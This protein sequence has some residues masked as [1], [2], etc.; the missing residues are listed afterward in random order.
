MLRDNW[1]KELYESA[2][3]DP[4]LG[5]RLLWPIDR[6]AEL[7]CGAHATWFVARIDNSAWIGRRAGPAAGV[8]RQARPAAA[9]AAAALRGAR[10][11]RGPAGGA[12]AAHAEATRRGASRAASC[13]TRPSAWS[14]RWPTTPCSR[15]AVEALGWAAWVGSGA[16]AAVGA[17]V[18]Y[19]GN[20]HYTFDHGGS[21]AASWLKFQL[22]AIGGAVQGMAIVALG[23][24]RGWHYLAAQVAATLAGL[25]VT[26]AVNRWWTFR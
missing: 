4:A 21:L 24:H 15:F 26:Y 3:F 25:V 20:R 13:A 19:F 23:V 11:T 6:L 7:T 14:R 22:T 1:R 12:L 17:Q 16:G 5:K 2:R 8:R 18:A 10:V 9:R